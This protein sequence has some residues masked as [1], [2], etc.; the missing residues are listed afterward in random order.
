MKIGIIV[1]SKSGHTLQAAEVLKQKLAA[2]GLDVR[3][4]RVSAYDESPM[5]KGSVKLKSAPDISGYDT[6]V[7]CAWV[8]GG[9]LCPAMNTYLSGN[10]NLSGKTA[11]CMITHAFPFKSWGGTQTLNQTERLLES[12][13]ALVKGGGIV[14]WMGFGRKSRI[15]SVAEWTAGLI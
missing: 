1:N 7:V 11:V 4:E 5:D 13:G 10:N 6:L 9:T 12:K 8:M 2:R 14:N 15:D 3:L